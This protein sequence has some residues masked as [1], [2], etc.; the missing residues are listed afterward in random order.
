MKHGLRRALSPSAMNINSTKTKPK[1]PWLGPGPDYNTKS[2]IRG[3]Q[4]EYAF[5]IIKANLGRTSK[6][7]IVQGFI[8]LGP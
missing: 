5:S 4:L 3:C 6:L 7:Q 8:G 2:I 1:R